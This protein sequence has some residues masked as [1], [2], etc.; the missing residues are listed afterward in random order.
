MS[1]CFKRK[2]SMLINKFKC[3]TNP[4]HSPH[5][6]YIISTLYLVKVWLYYSQSEI[7]LISHAHRLDFKKKVLATS[8]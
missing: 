8:R 7:A 3:I 6:Q 4:T 2:S 5:R 1:I